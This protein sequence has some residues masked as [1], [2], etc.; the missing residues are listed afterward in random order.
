MNK[1]QT[2]LPSPQRRW[3]EAQARVVVEAL[4]RS[5]LSVR[6]F[7]GRHGL[8]EV[9][10]QR[11]HKRLGQAERGEARTGF[12]PAVVRLPEPAGTAAGVTVRL[13]D[14]VAIELYNGS[15]LTPVAL[16]DLVRQLRGSQR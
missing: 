11:W 13:P 2:K 16:A 15:L 3:N 12:V 14:G 9:R 10:V 4:R 5:G 7:A 1:T 6:E 8:H